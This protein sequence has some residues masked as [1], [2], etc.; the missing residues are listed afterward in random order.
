VRIRPVQTS[1]QSSGTF[2]ARSADA[3]TLQA[4]A[5]GVHLAVLTLLVL[6]HVDQRADAIQIIDFRIVEVPS[7]KAG[8]PV[9]ARSIQSC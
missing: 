2:A 3:H 6:H 8:E 4:L 7:G 5:D 9:A 1:A